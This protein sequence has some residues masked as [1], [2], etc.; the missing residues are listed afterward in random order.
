MPMLVAS[1]LAVPTPHPVPVK[2][3]EASTGD[4]SDGVTPKVGR[5]TKEDAQLDG[6]VSR[7]LDVVLAGPAMNKVEQKKF[8]V[9]DRVGFVVAVSPL[10]L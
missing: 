6:E 2:V 1:R 3:A 10:L 9:H 4:I 7:D 5:H 8:H